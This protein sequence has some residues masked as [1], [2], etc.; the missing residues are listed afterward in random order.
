MLFIAH[1]SDTRG[2]LGSKLVPMTP[3]SIARMCGVPLAVYTELLSELEIHE[4]PSRTS[5]GTLFSRRMV[6]DEKSRVSN[7]F[8]QQDYRNSHKTKQN[9]NGDVTAMSQR[10]LSSSSSSTT[11]QKQTTTTPPQAAFVLPNWVPVEP[12]EAFVKM[13]TRIR[14]PLSDR[15]KRGIVR[16]LERLRATGNNIGEV[17]DRS[18]QNCWKGVLW[19]DGKAKASSYS[20]APALHQPGIR[21]EFT[22]Q[23]TEQARELAEQMKGWTDAKTR[24]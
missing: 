24:K 4:V 2:Y 21:R 20:K 23:E 19:P 3:D 6:R 11:K 14:A 22:E 18:E 5:T 16:D 13:R 15:A 1:N 8:R 9:S 12:W 10:S 7:K 17:L